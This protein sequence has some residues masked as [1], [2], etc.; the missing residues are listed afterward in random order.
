[1][2][3]PGMGLA[4]GVLELTLAGLAHC[5]EWEVPTGGVDAN[6]I[7]MTEASNFVV[8]RAAPLY[9]T[10]ARL[11]LPQCHLIAREGLGEERV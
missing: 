9:A 1:M 11:R 6:R 10:P 8:G 4:L 3:P 2:C 5:F 7:D